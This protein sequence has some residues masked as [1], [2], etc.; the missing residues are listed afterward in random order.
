MPT[1]RRRSVDGVEEIKTESQSLNYRIHTI[2]GEIQNIKE[3]DDEDPYFPDKEG[4]KAMCVLKFESPCIAR[5]SEMMLKCA[6]SEIIM[7]YLKSYA[8]TLE[9]SVSAELVFK[10][11]RNAKK[12][13]MIMQKAVELAANVAI[14]FD[15]EV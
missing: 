3:A 13:V 1:K 2:V 11:C 12:S 6:H 14:M 10:S 4:G 15:D 5:I 7:G 8:V 9:P